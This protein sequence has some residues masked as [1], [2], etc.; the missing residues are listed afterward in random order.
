MKTPQ[1]FDLSGRT[2]MVTGGGR[3]IGR[4][5]ALGLAE[6]GADVFAVGRS[7]EHLDE[8][9]RAIEK[10]GRRGWS[11]QADLSDPEQIEAATRAV[12]QSDDLVVSLPTSAGKTRIAELCILRCLAGGRALQPRWSLG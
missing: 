8:A 7:R 9:V 10:A 11:L 6:A 12:D 3:G 1:L 2:A 4:H 5:I